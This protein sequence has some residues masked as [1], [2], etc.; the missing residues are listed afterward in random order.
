MCQAVLNKEQ[1]AE[2][3]RIEDLLLARMRS[4][5]KLM[6]EL[7][8]SKPNQELLGATEFRLRD[9]CLQL[10]GCALDAALE[11]RKKRGIEDRA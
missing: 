9:M 1:Q 11:E 7:L 6:A 3:N 2:A 10:G 4:E 8:A 5:A